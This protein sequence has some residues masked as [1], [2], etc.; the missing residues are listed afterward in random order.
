MATLV[1]EADSPPQ[2]ALTPL[3]DNI[4]APFPAHL[5]PRTTPQK[6]DSCEAKTLRQRSESQTPSVYNPELSTL[7]N[8]VEAHN[9]SSVHSPYP[10][11]LM[12]VTP[13]RDFGVFTSSTAI[14]SPRTQLLVILF[15]ST[16][17]TSGASSASLHARACYFRY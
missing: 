7:T 15:I 14:M 9:V 16:M 1:R 4:P 5:L 13:G 6:S 11:L 8:H 10:A 17:A 12:N 3:S 2:S